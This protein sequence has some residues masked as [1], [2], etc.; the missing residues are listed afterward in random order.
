LNRNR[1]APSRSGS[2]RQ[3]EACAAEAQRP[4]SPLSRAAGRRRGGSRRATAAWT[5]QA[6]RA[7]RRRRATP[8]NRVAAHWPGLI[9]TGP[10]AL[11][12]VGARPRVTAPHT[13][14]TRMNV[15]AVASLPPG[16]IRCAA[17]WP[18][19]TQNPSSVQPRRQHG[20]VRPVV[21]R[22]LSL[23]AQVDAP[24]CPA[25]IGQ[26]PTTVIATGVSVPPAPVLARRCRTGTAGPLPP[27]CRP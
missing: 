27:W 14:S 10:M 2:P 24:A 23:G 13:A 20:L 17:V 8:A 7:L 16:M 12:A 1:P 4:G 26:R 6:S 15:G 22:Q 9:I 21:L 25:L 19:Q 3:A 11:G 18:I 5:D